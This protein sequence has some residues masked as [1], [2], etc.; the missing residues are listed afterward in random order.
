MLNKQYTNMLQEKDVIFEIFQYATERAKV[1]GAENIYDFSLGNPSVSAS[2]YC[3]R[4]NCPKSENF[5][6]SCPAWI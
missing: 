6:P 5:R 2:F 4:N 3:K 1:V